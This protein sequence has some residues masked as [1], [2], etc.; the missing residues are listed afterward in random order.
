MPRNLLAERDIAQAP[1]N[2]LK[3]PPRNLL[4]APEEEPGI[5]DRALSRAGEKLGDL[6]DKIGG[7]VEKVG[8]WVGPGALMMDP[9]TP[10]EQD[11]S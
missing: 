4:A 6:G 10:I 2:L 5:I 8:E 7:A 9:T 1:R 11:Q 3:P